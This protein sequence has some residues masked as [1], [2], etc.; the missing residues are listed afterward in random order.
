MVRGRVII[1]SVLLY[2]A[3]HPPLLICSVVVWLISSLLFHPGSRELTFLSYHFLEMLLPL[4]A[5]RLLCEYSIL[6][7]AFFKLSE[8]YSKVGNQIGRE[9]GCVFNEDSVFIYFFF[10]IRGVESNK[11]IGMQRK[12]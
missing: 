5:N 10:I 2:L 3:V 12:T 9:I 11:I 4:S 1:C 6:L 7:V 8:G